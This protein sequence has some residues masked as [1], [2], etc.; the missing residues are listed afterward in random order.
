MRKNYF[1][2]IA[3]A[4]ALALTL[5]G[6]SPSAVAVAQG[7]TDQTLIEF[8][9]ANPHDFEAIDNLS[10]AINGE[11]YWVKLPNFSQE[12][13]GTEAARLL[14][15]APPDRSSRGLLPSDTFAVSIGRASVSNG[16]Y[17]TGSVIFKATYAGQAAPLDY[18]SMQFNIPS[19][20]YISGHTIATYSGSGGSTNLGYLSDANIANDAPI[21]RIEDKVSGFVNLAHRSSASV[22]LTKSGCSGSNTVQAAYRY[23]HNQSGAI[24]SIGATF[25]FLTLTYSNT[26][27]RLQK[28]S[29]VM[30]WN[31]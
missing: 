17:V 12:L 11:H 25:G 19:C 1:G 30:T 8:I 14:A 31:W 9:Q 7:N 21:W 6:A 28:S 22:L 10:L 18:S 4:T 2:R 3:V 27:M 13:T 5:F 16:F 24:S 15:T 20:M 23:E 26:P 29:S